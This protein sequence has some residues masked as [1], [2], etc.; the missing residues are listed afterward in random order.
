MSKSS[1]A[2][3]KAK[4]PSWF[5]LATEVGRA[6]TELGLSIP[7]RT[8]YRKEV[9]GDGHPV[10]VLPGFMASD[11][12]TAPLRKF[13][14]NLGYNAYAWE[15][16]RN[17]AKL[18]FLEALLDKIDHI[19]EETGQK[20]SIIGWSLGGIYARQIAKEKPEMIRQVITLGSPFRGISELNNAT[21]LYNLLPGSKRVVDLNPILLEDLPL[22]APV[23]TTAIYTKE[24]GIVPW[25]SCLEEE[26]DWL[27]QN[28]QVRGSHLGLGVNPSVLE[29]IMD[30]LQ[31][32]EDNWA[33][34]RPQ[35]LIKDFLFYP[36][37]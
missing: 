33:H 14:G 24:D 34:F 30:R 35:N 3:A 6:V 36:S 13:I 16:G 25:Q 10:L 23:P 15:L 8:L 19:Y 2:A 17:Y 11:S 26:E 22:P 1:E 18:R 27:H 31:Y 12:S 21:W 20:V 28:I 4:K 32:S 5:W 9:C 29:I 7:F 37:L